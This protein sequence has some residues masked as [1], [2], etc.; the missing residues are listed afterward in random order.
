MKTAILFFILLQFF[1]ID[2]EFLRAQH[3]WELTGPISFNA[4]QKLSDGKI[5][6]CT[7]AGSLYSSTDEGNSWSHKLISPRRSFFCMSFFDNTH[8]MLGAAGQPD[9]GYI[10]ITSDGGKT[11]SEKIAGSTYI[12]SLAFPSLDTAYV[13]SD[14]ACFRTID[15]GKTWDSLPIPTNIFFNKILFTD[16]RNGFVA[17]ENGILFRTTN[18]GTT[19]G[20]ILLPSSITSSITAIDANSQGNVVFGTGGFQIGISNDNGVHWSVS[21]FSGADTLRFPMSLIKII[22]NDTI[23]AFENGS[24]YRLLSLD[25]GK[26][27]HTFPL[28]KTEELNPVIYLSNATTF[29]DI[30]VDKIGDGFAIGTWGTIYKIRNFGKNTPGLFSEVQHHCGLGIGTFPYNKEAT[31]LAP[32]P[33]NSNYIRALVGSLYGLIS[34]SSDGGGTWF[35]RNKPLYGYLNLHSISEND[36]VL[37][38]DRISRSNDNGVNWIDSAFL[39]QSRYIGAVEGN[40]GEIFFLTDSTIYKSSDNGLTISPYLKYFETIP[41]D[42]QRKILLSTIGLAY[43]FN[44]DTTYIEVTT[45]DSMF[46]YTSG[47]GYTHGRSDNLVVTTDGGKHW[48]KRFV[49]PD[50]LS[51]NTITFIDPQIGIAVFKDT[52]KRFTVSWRTTDGGTHWNEISGINTSV[53]FQDVKFNHRGSLG[54]ALGEFGDMWVTLDS[55]RTW[56]TDTLVYFVPLPLIDAKSRKIVFTDDTTAIIISGIGFWRKTFTVENSSV[57]A[58]PI[59]SNPYLYIHVYPSPSIGPTIH[60]TVYGLYSVPAEGI[61]LKLYDLLGREVSDLR[62]NIHE[63][64]NGSYSSFDISTSALHPGV[65]YLVLNTG[66]GGV[67]RN[68]IIMK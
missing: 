45:S 54:I 42:T 30:Y 2:V 33:Q 34:F 43:F 10:N 48:T 50:T 29:N 7:D 28:H 1:A 11:W 58:S 65:Y 20:K 17:G 40:S 19:W 68:I 52:A 27:W 26:S 38:G 15:R 8:G 12:K 5:V 55:G 41:R 37:F 25:L 44:K 24:S 39:P 31:L 22:G 62:T 6:I 57:L 21:D 3:Q 49:F 59:T 4:V 18:G 36:I 46:H 16:S 23:L 35:S 61:S 14:H 53:V 51:L 63:N 56:K 32:L 13:C 60:C 64:N 9:L 47:F 67:T 66:N